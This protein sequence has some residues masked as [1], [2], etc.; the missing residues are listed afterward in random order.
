LP[1]APGFASTTK[2]WRQTSASLSVTMRVAMSTIPP[3][4]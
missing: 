2:G 4:G 1:F 3:A